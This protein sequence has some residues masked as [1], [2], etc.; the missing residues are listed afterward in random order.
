MEV[1]GDRVGLTKKEF[2]ILSLLFKHAGKVLS[3]D[4]IK[5]EIWPG[6][7]LYKWSRSLDVHIQ[8]LRAKLEQSPEQ[9]NYILTI[10]G[11]GYMLSDF[12]SV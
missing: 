10:P 6:K 2:D 12:D 3:R 8:H 5:Q 11:V 4:T 7:K 9:P 1:D